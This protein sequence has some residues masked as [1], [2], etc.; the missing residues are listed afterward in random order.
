MSSQQNN[1][2]HFV[3]KVAVVTL[4]IVIYLKGWGIE[5][6]IKR[7]SDKIPT[8]QMTQTQPQ[9][10]GEAKEKPAGEKEASLKKAELSPT[11]FEKFLAEYEP[12]AR[13]VKRGDAFL[14][15]DSEGTLQI[16]GEPVTYGGTDGLMLVIQYTKIATFNGITRRMPIILPISLKSIAGGPATKIAGET[17]IGD[18]VLHVLSANSSECRYAVTKFLK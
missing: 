7:V 4:L 11:P 3:F 18:Y 10:Q 1:S 16:D 6:E 13:T 5:S 9:P 14:L 17:Y 15:D 8:G 2:D 12:K